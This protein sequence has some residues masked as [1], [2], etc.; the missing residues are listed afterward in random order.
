[1]G[2]PRVMVDGAEPSA[3]FV[4]VETSSDE[5]RLVL[6]GEWTVTNAGQLTEALDQATL[7]IGQRPVKGVVDK[8]KKLDTTGA[9][10]LKSLLPADTANGLSKDHRR[11]LDFLPSVSDRRPDQ[12]KDP[13]TIRKLFTAIGA[14]TTT[15]IYFAWDI[16]TFIGRAS[17]RL[18]QNVLEPRRFRIPSIIRHIKE[19]GL[20]AFAI[21]GL[22]AVLIA[23]V[24]TYQAAVQLKRFGAD[25]YTVDLTVIALLR[26]MGVLVTAIMV[27]GR[28]GSAFATEIGVMKLRDEVSAL[29]TMGM[30]PIEVLVVPRIIAL[31]ITLPLLTFLADFIG[32][33]GG[34]V[35]SMSLL[36]MSLRQYAERVRETA[37]L[38]T[39]F[40]G[41]IKAPVFAGL[42]A[43]IGC[44]QG[45]QVSGSAESIGRRTTLAV[46]QAIFFV[47][48]AD[49]LFSVVF[50]EV[51]I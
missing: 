48:M 13:P 38:T 27:A 10:L 47:I 51:G 2:S 35:M 21:V 23:M 7:D 16:F 46:V 8:I 50:S 44:Y 26:E 33:V 32:L 1:M 31:V 11:V 19:T 41:M 29:T 40:V 9:L 22:L 18:G 30:D 43:V 37:D 6:D 3:T 28:S 5:A 42:I 24:I 20:N 39:F 17:V 15:G 45:L 36:D 49:A 14:R 34:A 12:E 4:L 25:I